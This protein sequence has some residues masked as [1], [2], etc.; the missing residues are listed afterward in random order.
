VHYLHL[1]GVY[2]KFCRCLFQN[3]QVSISN[4]AGVYFKFCMCPF[5]IL[6]VSISNIA[7][8]HFKFF[9]CPYWGPKLGSHIGFQVI[10]KVLPIEHKNA[11]GQLWGQHCLQSNSIT[12][13]CN[14]RIYFQNWITL[15]KK[16][17]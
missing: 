3:L 12:C 11:G 6:H 4:F 15:K 10:L 9:R 5:Q 17:L 1:A 8:V 13:I 16:Q 14:N 2:F 7:G